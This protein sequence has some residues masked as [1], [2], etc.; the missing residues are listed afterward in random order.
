MKR[1]GAQE[2]D[3]RMSPDAARLMMA[4][5]FLQMYNPKSGIDEVIEK[6]L[7][8]YME[9]TGLERGFAFINAGE[10]GEQDLREVARVQPKA[11]DSSYNLS[12]S[13]IK[14]AIDNKK[15]IIEDALDQSAD[16]T[17]TVVDF[18]ICSAVVVP[19]LLMRSLKPCLLWTSNWLQK[20]FPHI[21]L[22]L[23]SSYVI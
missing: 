5:G 18:K 12:R 14:K 2:E 19:L 23:L 11:G 21:Y 20:S 15:V 9:M 6:G 10:G 17:Q 4:M 8:V 3:V 16:K 22:I 13:F 1:R 7:A